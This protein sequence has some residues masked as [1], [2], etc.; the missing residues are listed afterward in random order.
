MGAEWAMFFLSFI[1]YALS[2]LI[3]LERDFV[4]I[5]CSYGRTGGL[6]IKVRRVLCIDRDQSRSMRSW[7]IENMTYMHARSSLYVHDSH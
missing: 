6:Y 3:E 1:S 5:I 7:P 2:Y 4:S